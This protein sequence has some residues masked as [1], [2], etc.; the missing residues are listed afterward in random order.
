MTP[1]EEATREPNSGSQASANAP[2][3]SENLDSLK[4]EVWITPPFQPLRAGAALGLTALG[5][6]LYEWV[7][8]NFWSSESF[9]VHERYPW[10]SYLLIAIALIVALIAVRVALGIWSPHAKLGL[11]ILAFL[12]CA[13]IGIG[14]GRFVS[15]TLR[16]TLNPRYRLTLVAGERFPSF[17]LPDQ[18]GVVHDGPVSPAAKAT[19]LYVY[20]GD[21]CPFARHELADLNALGPE[22]EKD[23]VQI[24]AISADPV[25]RSKM[26]SG[27]LHSRIPLLSD[28]HETLLAPLGLVQHHRDGE[29][30]NAIPA[31]FVMDSG[32][33]VRWIFTS[34]FYRQ[35]PTSAELVAAAKA[36]ANSAA[37]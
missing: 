29:P 27:Y 10:Q 17:T 37:H 5:F 3:P 33:T 24:V 32:G 34:P 7:L 9:G 6:G 30:D 1:P 31:F 13:A 15:Y 12:A 22:L 36:A 21:F 16:G 18:N 26:L 2:A 19:L 20:R 23:G 11:S 4:E 8:L 25:A 14:G 35:L 28:E